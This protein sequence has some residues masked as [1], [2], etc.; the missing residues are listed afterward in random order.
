MYGTSNPDCTAR[1]MENTESFPPENNDAKRITTSK[2][3][4]NLTYPYSRV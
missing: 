4:I 1:Y 2:S 3:Q